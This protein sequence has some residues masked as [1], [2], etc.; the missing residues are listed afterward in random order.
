MRK[1]VCIN[2]F[3][4]YLKEITAGKASGIHENPAVIFTRCAKNRVYEPLDDAEYHKLLTEVDEMS[5]LWEQR[6]SENAGKLMLNFLS[7]LKFSPEKL[8]S[9]A[10]Y[11]ADCY[12]DAHGGYTEEEDIPETDPD[13]NVLPDVY[14]FSGMEGRILPDGAAAAQSSR[15]RRKEAYGINPYLVTSPKEFADYLSGRIYGQKEAV[16]AA[17]LLLFNHIRK[18]K[19]N[20][21]FA[22]PTGCGKTEIWRALQ[23]IYPWIR[24][25]DS[26]AITMQ[27]WKGS[28]KIEDIFTGMSTDE[29]EQSIIVFDEF[30]KFCE[31]VYSSGGNMAEKAQNELL[32][33][34]EG[35]RMVFPAEDG[36]K[37]L[38]FDSSGISFVFCGSFEGLVKERRDTEEKETIGFGRDSRRSDIASQY[39]RRIAPQDL[40]KYANIRQEIAGRINQVV[41]LHPMT[42]DDYRAILREESLSPLHALEKQYKVT[43]HLDENMV[44]NLTAEAE[45]TGFGVRYLSSRLQEYLDEQMYEDCGRKEYW[46]GRPV[47]FEGA[48]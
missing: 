13:G 14:S 45:K 37:T 7:S 30:D 19:R 25:V 44:E 18:R 27:G 42:A 17:S 4:K 48:M 34:I 29:I 2:W 43:L 20:I 21:L 8:H 11:M 31:P 33:L 15:E 12:A 32:K 22:G 9:F 16:K 39:R 41:Q 36:R 38:N 46:L 23:K 35:G 28:F 3:E 6:P 24:I 40:V 1:S 10:E 47:P 26:T 5:D